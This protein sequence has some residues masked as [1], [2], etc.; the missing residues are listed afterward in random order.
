[1]VENIRIISEFIVF[2]EKYKDAK[3]FSMMVEY[4]LPEHFMSLLNKIEDA[5]IIFLINSQIL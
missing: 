5:D 3:Y 1:M 4:M 2:G